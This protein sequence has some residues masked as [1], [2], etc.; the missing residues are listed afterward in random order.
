MNEQ[1]VLL[2]DGN[3]LSVDQCY[4]AIQHRWQI[5]LAPEVPARLQ[6]SRAVVERWISEGETVY[7]ITTGFGALAM[8]RISP[9]ESRQ[10]QHNLILSHSAGVGEFIP[11]DIARA[12]LLLRINA[13]AKGYSGV[14]PELIHTLLQFLNSGYIA[15]IPAKGSVG[16][17][18][19]LAPLAHLI[20]TLKGYGWMWSPEDELVPAAQ[21]LQTLGLPPLELQAKEGLALINGTQMMSAYGV[22]VIAAGK[23]L[24]QL[25]DIIGAMSVDALRGSDT[26]FDPFIHQLRPHPGQQQSA[27]NL[28]MLLADSQIRAS[29]RENDPRVQDPYSIRCIPQVHGA[30]RDTLTFAETVLNREINAATDNPLIDPETERHFE[31]GNFHGEPIALVLDYLAIAL[32]ELGNI[33]ERRIAQMMMGYGGLPKFLTAAG[34]LHSGFMIAQYTAAALVGE[35]KVLAHPASVDSIP[36]SANQ[37]DH[38]SFGSIAAVKA[39]NI[40]RNLYRILAIELLCATQALEYHRP[41]KSSPALETVYAVVREKIPPY[42]SDRYL[43]DDIAAVESLLHSPA[44]LECCARYGTLH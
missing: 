11:P 17:S 26:P 34:G 22:F 36:T 9:E 12:M 4:A 42:R 41:L 19:D 38:N 43:A 23:H 40:V 44:L 30:V 14:R 33:S 15:A 10:L 21:A 5:Q 6:R 16:S 1:P 29:H 2:L 32:S 39:W 31:G 25:A 28:R 27:A 13:L 20:A 8:Q 18:G 7:G 3:S 37:E 35:N 24:C